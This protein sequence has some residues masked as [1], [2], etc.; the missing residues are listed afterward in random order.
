MVTQY[1]YVRHHLHKNTIDELN[2]GADLVIQQIAPG[3]QWQLTGYRNDAANGPTNYIVLTSSGLILDIEGFIPGI[4]GH[5]SEINYE[6]YKSPF[7]I[8]AFLNSDG[9]SLFIGIDDDRSICGINDDLADR[10]FSLDQFGLWLANVIRSKI[11]A[12]F[13]PFI[14]RRNEQP[15]G[16]IV[17]I[18]DVVEAPIP[19]FVRWKD[20][21]LFYVREGEATS[22]LDHEKF[23]RYNQTKWG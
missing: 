16:K 11:G 15:D 1:C 13:A 17:Y 6:T 12:E 4:I 23:Y 20:R 3:G 2:D 19:A 22:E 10:Q 7:E 5:V 9:G 21:I 8:A 18:V 14:G